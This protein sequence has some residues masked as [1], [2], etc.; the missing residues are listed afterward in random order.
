MKAILLSAV[1]FM[2]GRFGNKS[3][4]KPYRKFWR[5]MTW[6]TS[7]VIVAKVVLVPVFQAWGKC[8]EF[9]NYVIWN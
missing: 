4:K 5:V 9:I 1:R 7:A 3:L 8:V 2:N 6:G